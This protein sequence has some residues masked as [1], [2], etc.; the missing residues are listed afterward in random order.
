MTMLLS[1]RFVAEIISFRNPGMFFA[2]LPFDRNPIVSKDGKLAV[3]SALPAQQDEKQ[4]L[5]DRL[6][7]FYG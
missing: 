4:Q 3:G 2:T 1:F 6:D 5:Q 7:A